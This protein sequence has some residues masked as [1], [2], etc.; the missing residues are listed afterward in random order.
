MYKTAHLFP[1]SECIHG[2]FGRSGGVSPAP[3]DTLNASF[4]V[5]DDSTNVA[6]NREHLLQALL[7][8]TYTLATVNQV[9]G[10][11]VLYIQ[12]Q[13]DAK[14]GLTTDA[15]A[16]VTDVPG[17]VLGVLTADCAPILLY[18]EKKHRIG[19]IHA[20]WKGA[21]LGIVEE[22]IR[23][24]K[25]MGSDPSDIIA[26]IGPCIQQ[27]SYPVSAGFRRNFLE[28]EATWKEFFQEQ[29]AKEYRFDLSR[30]LYSRLAAVG[31]ERIE[32]IRED[33]YVNPLFF[34]FR[35]AQNGICGRQMSVIALTPKS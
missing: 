30:F 35:K 7:I 32:I 28:K 10:T 9:H 2:F 26:A 11:C 20:G 29:P 21:F 3:Y 4:S 34:S 33:T 22:T 18:D 12:S 25:K 1:N 14:K 8:N 5:G 6:Q 23:I 27:E 31:V 17:V 19:A 16:L 24:L 15:D 13:Q